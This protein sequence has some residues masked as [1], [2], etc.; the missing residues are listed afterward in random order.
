MSIIDKFLKNIILLE[1]EGGEL[2]RFNGLIFYIAGRTE[3]KIPHL[4]FRNQ[5]RIG[6]IRLDIAE[7]FPHGNPLKYTDKLTSK[8]QKIFYYLMTAKQTKITFGEVKTN[9][10]L[11]LYLWNQIPDVIQLDLNN[12]VPDYKNLKMP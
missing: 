5:D 10:Q 8:E 3:G 11:S 6:A 1:E 9:Y 7:Y 4:H 2:F 12:Q